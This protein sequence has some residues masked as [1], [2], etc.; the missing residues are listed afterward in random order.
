[1]PPRSKRRRITTQAVTAPEASGN[2][3]HG[4]GLATTNPRSQPEISSSPGPILPT[5]APTTYLSE[6]AQ[7]QSTSSAGQPFDQS[8]PATSISSDTPVPVPS[9]HMIGTH[10]TNAIK[11]R[12]ISGQFIDL[13][14]LATPKVGGEEKKLVINS[15]GEIISKDANPKKIETIEQWTDL[16]LIYASVYLSA[17]PAKTLDLLK[18]IQTVRMGV[19]RGALSWKDYDTQYRL[20]KEQD[21]SS[22]W[23]EVDSELWLM[24]MTPGSAHN[25]S[26]APKPAVGK[27]YNFNFKGSCDKFP[28]MYKHNCIR[29]GSNHSMLHCILPVTS[30]VSAHTFRPP[31]STNQLYGQ[32]NSRP[33]TNITNTNYRGY[34]Y[35]TLRPISRPRFRSP[36]SMAPRYNS[37]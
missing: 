5:Q 28:C 13:V 12:I 10:V 3:P 35:T 25:T 6:E 9:I 22:S 24:Y 2:T 17:H 34:P 21:P 30:N 37:H 19:N 32:Q 15:L 36:Q 8:M 18:Y 20:R 14:T 23:G 29:C 11:Q 7:S 1:M 31:N 33:Q 4:L 27:C 26:N 16:M